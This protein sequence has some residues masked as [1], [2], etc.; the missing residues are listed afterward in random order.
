MLIDSMSCP[1]YH[2]SSGCTYV[3]P[4]EDECCG[5]VECAPQE[6]RIGEDHLSI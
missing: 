6:Q 4:A 3:P 5:S 2:V 1:L